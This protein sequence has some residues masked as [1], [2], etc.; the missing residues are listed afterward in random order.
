MSGSPHDGAMLRFGGTRS[1]GSI[2]HLRNTETKT[3]ETRVLLNTACVT[4]TLLLALVPL[5]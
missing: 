5:C 2:T 3:R 1:T 4:I